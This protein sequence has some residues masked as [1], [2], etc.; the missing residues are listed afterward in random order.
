MSTSVLASA[1][2]RPHRPVLA[3]TLGLALA[4]TAYSQPIP[5]THDQKPGEKPMTAPK[6]IV[7]KVNGVVSYSDFGAKGDGTSD[8][9]AAIAAA[10]KYANEHG[11]PSRPMTHAFYIAAANAPLPS[12]PTPTSV[13]PNSS[14]TTA[15]SRSKIA[16]PTS[17]RSTRNS[18][19]SRP[20][21][22]AASNATRPTSASACPATALLSPTT[23]RSSATSATA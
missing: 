18:R 11:L 21:A 7:L 9:G 8:D 13:P 1:L 19:P 20:S 10:H 15:K 5:A 12:K 14:S 2:F 17:F 3:L 4:G 23:P 22:S 6:A 16:A